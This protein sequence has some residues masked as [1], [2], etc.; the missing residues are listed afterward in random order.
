M[1]LL[2]SLTF[3]VVVPFMF[4]QFLQTE[5]VYYNQSFKKFRNE[6]T[7]VVS[8]GGNASVPKVVVDIEG[9]SSGNRMVNYCEDVAEA[10][11]KLHKSQNKN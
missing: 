8:A 10:T 7:P 9:T 2:I 6:L 5:P 1:I 3:L 4:V 11:P